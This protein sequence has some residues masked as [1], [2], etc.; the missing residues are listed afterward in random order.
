MERLLRRVGVFYI[1][2]LNWILEV[3]VLCPHNFVSNLWSIVF[4]HLL[5]SPKENH[6]LCD[7]LEVMLCWISNLQQTDVLKEEWDEQMMGNG[8]G[9]EILK[10]Q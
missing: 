5:L 6:P 10:V 7:W 4:L 9:K 8:V 3:L 2:I 1:L